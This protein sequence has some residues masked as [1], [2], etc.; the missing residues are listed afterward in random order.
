MREKK[1]IHTLL[2]NSNYNG[3]FVAFHSFEDHTVVGEGS[4]PQLALEKALKK[5]IKQPVIT[6]VP[7]KGMIQIY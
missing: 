4:T 6:F 5:G 3:K 1:M 2:K 7:I